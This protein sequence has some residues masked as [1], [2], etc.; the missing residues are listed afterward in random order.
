MTRSARFLQLFLKVA[1]AYESL[2]G[3]DKLI[4]NLYWILYPDCG[5]HSAIIVD[6]V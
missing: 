4:Y 6:T 2:S 3:K 1:E 5:W